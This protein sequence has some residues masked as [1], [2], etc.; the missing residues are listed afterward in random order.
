MRNY[1]R[2]RRYAPVDLGP[3][4]LTRQRAQSQNLQYPPVFGPESQGDIGL[5][6]AWRPVSRCGLSPTLS[7]GH[8]HRA[9]GLRRGTRCLVHDPQPV[10]WAT[11]YDDPR[12]SG[13]HAQVSGLDGD[14]QPLDVAHADQFNMVQYATRVSGAFKVFDAHNALWLLH[15]RLWLAMSSGWGLG[16]A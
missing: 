1:C 6:R 10:D 14:E 8:L 15:K 4:L 5:L 2:W 12:R 13:R 16:K 11:F 9:D 3:A 7:P